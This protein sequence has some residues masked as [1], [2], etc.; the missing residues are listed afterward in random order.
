MNKLS[1]KINFRGKTLAKKYWLLL[2]VLA[3][4][5]W[6]EKERVFWSLAPNLE[7]KMT[8]IAWL[9]AQRLTVDHSIIIKRRHLEPPLKREKTR[10]NNHYW[11]N[12]MHFWQARILFVIQQ[13]FYL[14]IQVFCQHSNKSRSLW[15]KINLPWLNRWSCNLPSQNRKI[16]SKWQKNTKLLMS[17]PKIVIVKNR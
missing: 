13:H 4:E 9:G 11:T 5:V 10:P 1:E 7:Q 17:G 15:N 14:K 2:T 12:V 3:I 8:L 6:I 16:S